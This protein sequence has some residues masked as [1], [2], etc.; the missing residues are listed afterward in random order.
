MTFDTNNGSKDINATWF[1]NLEHDKR[2]QD[3]YMKIKYKQLD[4]HIY[5]NFNGIEVPKVS[6]I[7]VDF[8]GVMGV[9][10]T[11]LEKYNPQQFEIVGLGIATSGLEAGV[12]PYKEEHKIYRKTIQ[13]RGVV[14]SD[15]YYMNNGELIVPYAR[16]LI[17]HKKVKINEN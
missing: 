15:L 16:I 10:I 13:K 12:S 2:N 5:E 1:T 17:K 11:F 14:N 8:V 7:P 3:L 9:P 6:N 4:Y